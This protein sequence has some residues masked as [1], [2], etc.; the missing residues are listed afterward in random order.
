MLT[1]DEISLLR[2]ILRLGADLERHWENR[3]N[4]TI[5]QLK[6]LILKTNNCPSADLN[7]L[8]QWADHLS[9]ELPLRHFVGIMVPFERL[10]QRTLRDDEFIPVM[11]QDKLNQK[12]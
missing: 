8:S 6:S 10:A 5:A 11:N 1:A 7:R 2:E 4:E 9:F 3:S 12:P